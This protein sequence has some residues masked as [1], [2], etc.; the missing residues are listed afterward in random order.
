MLNHPA[1][2]I[3]GM[4]SLSGT[5]TLTAHYL[6]ASEFAGKTPS[7]DSGASLLHNPFLPF[8]PYPS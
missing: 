1:S 4:E 8:L 2:K 6:R 5:E 3:F 7:S